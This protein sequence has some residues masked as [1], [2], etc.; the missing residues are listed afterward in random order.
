MT[1]SAG[2]APISSPSHG[3]RSRTPRRTALA[4]FLRP[5]WAGV[6]A[7]GGGSCGVSAR[8][9][10][11]SAWHRPRCRLARDH[12]FLTKSQLSQNQY[13]LPSLPMRCSSVLGVAGAGVAVPS[14]PMVGARRCA[15]LA[16]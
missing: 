3:S 15:A 1:R 5:L 8:R 9:R 6:T 12:R 16:G 11:R 13:M 2:N 10:A 14:K 7:G 4:S